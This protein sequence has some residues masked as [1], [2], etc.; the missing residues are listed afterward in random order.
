MAKI[1]ADNMQTKNSW[2]LFNEDGRITI[3]NQRSGEALTGTVKL[4]RR[5]F[6]AFIRFYQ[7][8]RR[9]FGIPP[10]EWK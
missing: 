6:E 9:D 2:L 10:E 8:N 7:R 1:P 5:E 3:S 4:T